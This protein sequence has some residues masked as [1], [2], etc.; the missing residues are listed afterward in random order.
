MTL[1]D[2]QI[3]RWSR[4]ILVPE[5]GGRGQERLLAARVAV[6]AATAG[7]VPAAAVIDLPDRA[8]VRAA[9]A[10][11]PDG[12]DLAIDLDDDPDVAR[13]AVAAR[14]PLVRG[15]CAGGAGEVLALVGRPCGLCGPAPSTRRAAGPMDGPAAAATA[16]LV[17]AEALRLLLEPAAHGRRQHLDLVTGTFTGQALAADGCD[18]CRLAHT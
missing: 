15:R 18:C 13:A 10:R 17:A 7:G 14:V 4:Q 12:C 2:A 16:A 6:H 11:P 3:N 5:V 1:N 8:G 9:P